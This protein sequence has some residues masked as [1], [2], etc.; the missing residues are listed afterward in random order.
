MPPELSSISSLGRSHQRLGCPQQET[1]PEIYSQS[2]V[3]KL[4]L[5]FLVLQNPQYVRP[6][7]AFCSKVGE[8]LNHV[9]KSE[10]IF[11]WHSSEL[12]LDLISSECGGD[13]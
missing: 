8:T 11:G 10:L 1:S 3:P 7:S 6:V 4:I 12:S 2:S 9:L 5:F 13:L